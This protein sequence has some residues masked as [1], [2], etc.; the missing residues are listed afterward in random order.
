MG[1]SSCQ[2]KISIQQCT[3][4]KLMIHYLNVNRIDS[5]NTWNLRFLGLPTLDVLK[6]RSNSV[7]T[8]FRTL[9]IQT[10]TQQTVANQQSLKT[11]APRL[12]SPP[13]NQPLK[14][15]PPPQPIPSKHKKRDE[16]PTLTMPVW[17]N[18]FTGHVVWS[19]QKKLFYPASYCI[20]ID[21]HWMLHFPFK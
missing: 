9:P 18:Y 8:A 14:T 2:L 13:N 21:K 19:F 20:Y 15:S 4:P 12:D 10:D 3:L 6:H 1:L 11:V 16:M 5:I 17:P 7:K